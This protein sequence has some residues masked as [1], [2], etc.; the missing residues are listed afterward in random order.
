MLLVLLKYI[1]IL[2]LHIYILK[3]VVNINTKKIFHHLS[4]LK[5]SL[6]VRGVGMFMSLFERNYKVEMYENI[7]Q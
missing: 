5:G 7:Y 2:F 4:T 1:P 6:T 3:Y